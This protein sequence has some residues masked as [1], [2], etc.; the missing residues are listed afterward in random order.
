[1]IVLAGS[2]SEPVDEERAK[3]AIEQFLTN[4]S[5]RKRVDADLKTLRTGAQIEYVGKFAAAAS[6]AAAAD[7][8]APVAPVVVQPPAAAGSGISA[9]EIAKGMGLK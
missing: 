5:K 6:D 1:V 3:P 9:E 2:R 7:V 4:E 8:A